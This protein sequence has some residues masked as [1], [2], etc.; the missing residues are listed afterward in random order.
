[1]ADKVSRALNWDKVIGREKRMDSD[2]RGPS[3]AQR[4]PSRVY[5]GRLRGDYNDY[6]IEGEKGR[7]SPTGRRAMKYDPRRKR[8]RGGRGGSR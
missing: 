2:N 1:M 6:R 3:K 5:S 4:S 7:L 8:G